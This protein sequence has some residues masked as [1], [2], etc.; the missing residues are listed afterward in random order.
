MARR[1]P[2]SP[3]T[4]M[5]DYCSK[6]AGYGLLEVPEYWIVDPIAEKVTVCVLDH[7]FYDATE[8]NGSQGIPC[9]SFPER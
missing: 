9:P 7:G 8:W 3:S 5:D 6:R 2:V 1:D 4:Q